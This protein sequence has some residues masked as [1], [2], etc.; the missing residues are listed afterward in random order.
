M[1]I[2]DSRTK[3]LALFKHFLCLER[4]WSFNY[5]TLWRSFEVKINVHL[6]LPTL[7]MLDR[8]A[9]IL[10]IAIWIPLSPIFRV[11]TPFSRSACSAPT[12]WFGYPFY[13]LFFFFF[14]HLVRPLPMEVT[15]PPPGGGGRGHQIDRFGNV[16]KFYAYLSNKGCS[17][18]TW[19]LA[20]GLPDTA[21]SNV[22]KL[23][24][25]WNSIIEAHLWK[26]D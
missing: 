4:N 25:N 1:L 17:L 7:S 9:R 6:K 14:E 11:L 23:D 21:T 22:C 10:I 15:P 13:A 24:A 26:A 16:F 20:G 18:T 3:R 19:K 8:M 5:L 2:L 12:P